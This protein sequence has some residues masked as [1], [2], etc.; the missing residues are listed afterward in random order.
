MICKSHIVKSFSLV[1]F[2]AIAACFSLLCSLFFPSV[3]KVRDKYH[4]ASC[5]NNLKQ[6]GQSNQIYAENFNGWSVPYNQNFYSKTGVRWEQNSAFR[7]YN[8]WDKVGMNNLIPLDLACSEAVDKAIKKKVLPGKSN[9]S[10]SISSYY[11]YAHVDIGGKRSFRAVK[12]KG[13]K[14]PNLMANAA[15][16]WNSKSV[17][18]DTFDAR[19]FSKANFVFFDGHVES[20]HEASVKNNWNPHGKSHSP[21][22]DENGQ[23]LGEINHQE[24]DKLL[25]RKV[26]NFDLIDTF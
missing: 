1:D 2:L 25:T 15:D 10:P 19:H 12:L 21:W 18:P 5:I 8:M 11:S 17:R 20:L 6:L 3:M 23:T 14:S 16:V 22:A 13:L 26:L 9:K 24:L 4:A 7:E